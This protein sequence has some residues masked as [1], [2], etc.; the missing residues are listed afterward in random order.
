[1]VFIMYKKSYIFAQIMT[2][3]PRYQFDQ[4]V[5]KYNGNKYVRSFS[6]YQQFLVMAFGQLCFRDS[7]RSIIICLQAHRNKLYH[8]GFGSKIARKTL[9]DSNHKRNWRIYC[10]FALLLMKQVRPLYANQEVDGID[11]TQMV[12]ALDSSTVDLCLS[13]FN[14][15]HFRKTK[16]A[17]KLHTMIDVRGNIPIF[18]HISDG[19]MADS[20]VL[21]HLTFEAGAFYLIDRAYLDFKQLY[22][23]HT[24]Q[25]FFVIRTKKN[26]KL[27][28]Q[29]S[30]KVDKK[31]NVRC[32]QVVYFGRKEARLDYPA[33]LRRIKYYDQ[34]KHKYY[35]FLTN[36]FNLPALTITNLYRYRWQIELFFKWIKQNLKIKRFWGTSQNAVK[37]QIWIAVAVYLLVAL[38]KKKLKIKMEMSQ[39]L[40]ILSVSLFNDDQFLSLFAEDLSCNN[41]EQLKLP[42]Y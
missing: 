9:L 8:M 36:N 34:E 26:T 15:A 38:L 40:Q 27:S 22:R 19:K 35:V 12:Y 21:A 28:R 11:L 2:A 20:K 37:T 14:W 33:K 18:I 3:L 7:I 5:A 41:L 6:C 42:L 1:M 32:D 30:L 17:I 29:R 25:A 23:I 39:I 10:D 24:S 4:C 13:I 16:A 31:T